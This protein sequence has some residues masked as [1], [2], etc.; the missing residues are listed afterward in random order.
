MLQFFGF[1]AKPVE[2]VAGNTSDLIDKTRALEAISKKLI[3]DLENDFKAAIAEAHGL[4]APLAVKKIEK[5]REEVIENVKKFSDESDNKMNKSCVLE[6]P[7]APVVEPEKVET[8]VPSEK[9]DQPLF[10]SI[11]DRLLE[12]VNKSIEA[13]TKK[14]KEA[15][16]DLEIEA[17][18][19]VALAIQN[20][21][22]AFEGSLNLTVDK[23]GDLITVILNEI[24]KMV[25]DIQQGNKDDLA[26]L[27]NRASEFIKGL[28]LESWEPKL[29]NVGAQ[30]V[31]VDEAATKVLVRCEGNFKYAADDNY[32]PTLILKEHQ[33]EP[34][35]STKHTLEFEVPFN[36]AFDKDSKD[37]CIFGG[38]KVPYEAGWLWY[39]AKYSEYKVWLEVLPETK[40]S[41]AKPLS[42][43]VDNL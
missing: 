15:G 39:N 19:E 33:Y 34:I 8:A 35:K 6:A 10:G 20:A 14:A 18:A 4:G 11:L 29:L 26:G 38:L 43:V 41:V 12:D 37:N 2:T 3:A 16:L 24:K 21:K 32:K 25:V 9:I 7:I 36:D 5:I 27:S 13:A 23:I 1:G 40:K 31:A 28:P 30:C 17:G 42:E 22:Y